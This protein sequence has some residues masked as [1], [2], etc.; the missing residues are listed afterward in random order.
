MDRAT[1]TET[2]IPGD[3][4][5]LI[6]CV[7]KAKSKQNIQIIVTGHL[8]RICT[9]TGE[10]EDIAMRVAPSPWIN[11]PEGGWEDFISFLPVGKG[12][13]CLA[14]FEY[15][16]YCGVPQA[17]RVQKPVYTGNSLWKLITITTGDDTTV[18]KTVSQLRILMLFPEKP[19][20]RSFPDPTNIITLPPLRVLIE[21]PSP[22]NTPSPVDLIKHPTRT[23][24]FISCIS[25]STLTQ[26]IGVSIN[27]EV[28]T[29]FAGSGEGKPMTLPDKKE[30]LVLNGVGED[31]GLFSLPSTKI[32]DT[33]EIVALFEY[34]GLDGQVHPSAKQNPVCV[35]DPSMKLITIASKNIIGAGGND[36]EL[37][38]MIVT[39]F[40]I[41]GVFFRR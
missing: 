24:I 12:R 17:S 28:V 7:S 5:I 8:G 13:V 3:A 35:G 4:Q 37:R 38:I 30:V 11:G 6:S 19:N 26:R 15:I 40:P 14:R 32:C 2:Q 36:S 18:N 9:F 22:T 31:L 16:D 27:S 34:I 23:Q 1:P 29:T 39:A 25:N 21:R 10:G 41:S 33:P 20:L